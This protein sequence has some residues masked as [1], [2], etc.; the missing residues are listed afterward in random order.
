MTVL[1]GGDQIRRQRGV[2]EALTLLWR[3]K[4]ALFSLIYL[5]LLY[6]T[7]LAAP[8]FITDQLSRVDFDSFLLS[9]SLAPG[10]H[11]FG[12]DPLGRDV[13]LRILVASRVSLFISFIV[14]IGSAFLG[15]TLGVSA[16]VLPRLGR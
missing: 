9:P 6:A 8:L 5:I 14:V 11:I 2:I 10:G 1:L 15:L 4:K 12:T 3:D 7:A 13:F 16:G